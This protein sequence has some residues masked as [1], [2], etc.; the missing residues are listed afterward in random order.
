MPDREIEYCALFS[1]LGE[2][3]RETATS[4][5]Q[6]RA[7]VFGRMYAPSYNRVTYFNKYKESNHE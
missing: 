1:V 5:E 6:L 4:P 7:K 3:Y 2:T